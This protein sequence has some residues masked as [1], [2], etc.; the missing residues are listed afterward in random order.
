M[1]D[2]EQ[3]LGQ[4]Y[5][6][7]LIDECGQF[8][9][10]AWM[11]LYAR[12]IVNAACKANAHGHF[13]I[14]VIVGC[15][16]PLGPYYEY[17]RTVFVQK[18]PFDKPENAK[19]DNNGA[20]WVFENGEALCVYDPSLYAYQRSTAMDNP[21]FLA[22]DPGFLARMNSMPKAKRDK[23]LL[24]LDG[25]VEGQYF[26]CFDPWEHV[27]DLREDP[28]AI[29]WQPWQPVWA[30]QDWAMGGHYNAC[31]LFTKA[32]VRTIGNEYRTKTV[33]FKEMVLQGGKTH[34]VW[35]GLLKSMCK[36]N[37]QTVVPKSIFFSH[38]KFSKQVTGHTPADEYS[39]ELKA[40]GLPPVTR[41]AAAAGDRVGSASMVYN[42]L[43][44][45]ELVILDNCIDI[46]NAFPTLMRDPDMM[47]DVLKVST[48]G[49]DCWD[50]FR[51]GI[52]GMYKSRRKPE[53]LTIEEHA[54]KLDPLAAHFYRIKMLAERQNANVPFVQQE[55]PVW[56][57]KCG[58]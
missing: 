14:P 20:W 45:G 38:E 33:C 48:R 8:S 13:P 37:G 52:Y 21:K 3:Y 25:A 10:D 12:N 24:G 4:A 17:Y 39:V 58:A 42:M 26:D 29:Q 51:Y 2:I 16:N 46:I 19:K 5:C 57:S 18:E 34:K 40:L 35:A 1:R 53:E 6:A 23:M 11:M 54:K 55:Q 36:L 7:I 30:S 31:Y 41:A 50:A 32:L 49:D 56:Q 44:N 9:P 22:R 15:T 47:D 27:I 28:E 43:K